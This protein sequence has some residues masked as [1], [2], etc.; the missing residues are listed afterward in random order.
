[1]I[2][3]YSRGKLLLTG[4]Y[5]VLKGAN[6]LAV[7]CKMG[8]TLN[9]SPTKSNLLVWKSYDVN[10]NIWFEAEFK[11]DALDLITTNDLEIWKSLLKV[12]NAS[13]K[14]NSGFLKQGGQ[15]STQLEFER[16]WGLGSSSTL[17]SNVALWA[18][19]NPYLLLENSFGGSGYDIACAQAQGPLTYTRN[20]YEPD[21]KNILLNYPFSENLFF[22][23]LNK[24]KDSQKAVASFNLNKVEPSI[25]HEM[26]LL[27][28]KIINCSK[29]IEFNSLLNAHEQTIGSL[30]NQKTVQESHFSDFKGVVKSLGAWGGDFVLAS[31]NKDSPN[32]FNTM[33]YS[34]IIPFKEMLL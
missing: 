33:G 6:A 14:L 20:K 30:L 2:S 31:G 15:V 16:S 25:I 4:E 11:V 13:R 23:Y 29:Q 19:I 27:T 10:K 26:N 32:Y 17:I 9:Y 24:K 34:T 22:V 28:E 8:Q 5:V 3:Y 1:M 21:T 18:N 7:P 12:L